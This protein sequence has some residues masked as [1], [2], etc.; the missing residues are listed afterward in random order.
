MLRRSNVFRVLF[1]GYREKRRLAIGRPLR[2]LVALAALLPA[3]VIVERD[4]EQNRKAADWIRKRLGSAPQT[5]IILGSGLNPIADSLT[6]S[7]TVPYADIPHFPVSTVSGHKSR[8]VS[9]KLDGVPVIA[10]QGRFHFYEGHDGSNVVFP[11]RVLG[12]LGIKQLI[13]TNAAG[14]VNTSLHPG[15]LMLITDHLNLMGKNPLVGHNDDDLGPRFPDMSH[16]YS[17]RI[18]DILGRAAEKEKISL[19]RGVYAGM[20]GPTYETPA[21]VRMLRTLGADACGMS[22]VPEVIAARHMGLEVGGISCITN[23]GAGI[24]EGEL[25][26]GEVV[27]TASTILKDFSRLLKASIAQIAGGGNAP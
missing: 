5:A 6:E 24:L 17:R 16:A 3:S 4:T 21:E 13:V 14:A 11:V 19:A 8:F 10:M 1:P 9:G 12:A 23:M 27:E 15:Q 2:F 22:T 26:H 25:H 20:L 7:S 18:L